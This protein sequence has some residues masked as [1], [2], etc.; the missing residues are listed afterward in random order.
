ME[1]D[2]DSNHADQWEKAGL[3]KKSLPL[4]PSDWRLVNVGSKAARRRRE[5][6]DPVG[7]LARAHARRRVKVKGRVASTSGKRGTHASRPGEAPAPLAHRAAYAD[8]QRPLCRPGYGCATR[9]HRKIRMRVKVRGRRRVQGDRPARPPLTRPGAPNVPPRHGQVEKAYG[10]R[11]FIAPLVAFWW[12][13]P[14]VA[15]TFVPVRYTID[16]DSF[17]RV[18]PFESLTRCRRTGA[19]ASAAPAGSP[20][21]ASTRS[22]RASR[23]GRSRRRSRTAA[24]R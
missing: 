6:R 17:G 12:S 13:A 15:V 14:G 24:R 18:R 3:R 22:A 23:P 19:R 21:R 8:P 11:R 7:D 2:A 20:R 16:R 5:G 10:R 1:L 9:G 4:S